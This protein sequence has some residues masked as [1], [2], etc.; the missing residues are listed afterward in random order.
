MTAS[1]LSYTNPRQLL[2]DIDIHAE[3]DKAVA[4]ADIDNPYEIYD[5]L[6]ANGPVHRGDVLTEELGLP[7]SMAAA[8]GGREVFTFLGYDVLQQAYRNPSVF[9]S[10]VYQETI[11]RVQGVNL[12]QVDPPEHTRLRVLLTE[13]FNKKQFG[14][15]RDDIVDP[16]IA[17]LLEGFA[18]R[19][20]ADLMRD[21]AL[22][23]PI[24]VVQ[25]LLDFDRDQLG[26]FFDLAVGLQIIKTRPDLAMAS[27]QILGEIFKEMIDRHRRSPGDSM[28]DVLIQARVEENVPLSDEEI[29]GFVRVLLPAGA[30]TTTR[31]LGSLLVGLLNDPEQLALL[32][33]DRKLLPAAID[34][35]LRWE[36]PSQYNYRVTTEDTEVAGVQIPAGSGI[37][38][39][40]GAANR[41]PAR[42]VDP[43]HFDIRRKS[44]VNLAFGFGAH[45][46][47]GMHLARTEMGQ[48][49]EAVLDQL[50][51]LRTTPGAAPLRVQ[52]STFR[53]PVS[54]PVVWDESA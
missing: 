7:Y 45:I 5:R 11:G 26:D 34:E 33:E 22:W 32:R 54:V 37:N 46:C 48:A 39:C 9:S 14:R 44:G 30:E 38:L 50:P 10:T 8:G 19:N 36:A 15:W 25:E 35:A 53:W 20:E 47:I 52:G 49:M 3:Y 17:S 24:R 31:G 51:N 27:S 41:D 21:L 16:I 23:L 4:V 18:E 40:I 2:A 43:D 6:R 42:F 13:A 29:L 1:E 12:I 28:L